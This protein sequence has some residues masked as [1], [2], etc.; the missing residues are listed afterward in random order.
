MRLDI[1]CVRRTKTHSKDST[2]YK[3]TLQ[4]IKQR[5]ME[6][7]KVVKEFNE[8]HHNN[9]QVFLAENTHILHDL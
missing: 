1:S 8:E 5:L 2:V 6:P 4:Y 3:T 9:K 7:F